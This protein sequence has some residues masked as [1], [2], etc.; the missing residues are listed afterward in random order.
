MVRGLPACG[1]R[2]DRSEGQ[3]GTTQM[4][5]AITDC[6]HGPACHAVAM[7]KRL[8]RLRVNSFAKWSSPKLGLVFSV[9]SVRLKKRGL[10]NYENIRHDEVGDGGAAD[11][12]GRGDQC[13]RGVTK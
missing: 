10:Q 12:V 9:K 5:S 11:T 13:V 2:G 8:G 6:S 3:A 7:R 1:R 4:N